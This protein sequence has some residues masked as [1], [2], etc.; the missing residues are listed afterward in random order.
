[1]EGS[2]F[3]KEATVTNLRR[4]QTVNATRLAPEEGDPCPNA[5]SLRPPNRGGWG[6][7]G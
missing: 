6:Q 3:W 5:G 4:A 1:M 2:G 7:E